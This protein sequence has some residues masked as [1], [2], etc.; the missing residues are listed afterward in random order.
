MKCGKTRIN[1]DGIKEVCVGEE[2]Y[3][4][5]HSTNEKITRE[6]KYPLGSYYEKT[7]DVRLM[8]HIFEF[9]SLLW[10][11]PAYFTGNNLYILVVWVGLITSFISMV[12]WLKIEDNRRNKFNVLRRKKMENKSRRELIEISIEMFI[13]GLKLQRWITYLCDTD[14]VNEFTSEEIIQKSKEIDLEVD[15][16]IKKAHADADKKRK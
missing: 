14:R 8:P 9:A 7:K 11:I 6:I 2:G 10:L 1:D 5:Y 13:H 16:I 3:I 12:L 4:G 15:K